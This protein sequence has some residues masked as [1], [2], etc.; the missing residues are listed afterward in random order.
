MLAINDLRRFLSLSTRKASLFTPLYRCFLML[1]LLTLGQQCLNLWI[2]Q[3]TRQ[4]ADLIT[5]TLLVEKEAERL[6]N[7]AGNEKRA[8]LEDYTQER[9]AFGNSFDHLYNLVKGNHTQLNQL[10]QIK[11]L[12]NPSASQLGRIKLFDANRSTRVLAQSKNDRCRLTQRQKDKQIQTS[13]IPQSCFDEPLAQKAVLN[14]LRTQIQ[15]LLEQQEILLGERK[16]RLEQLYRIKTAMNILSTVAILLGVGL[17]IRHLHRKVQAPLHKL[18]EVGKVWQTGQMEVRLGYSSPN[19]IGQLAGVLDAM[20]DQAYQRQQHIE[21][22]NQNL[23]DL[24]SGLSHDMRTPLLATRTTL[25]CMLMGT[26]RCGDSIDSPRWSLSRSSN[27]AKGFP[28]AQ[29]HRCLP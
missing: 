18:T 21:V 9:N 23:K 10:E 13:Y 12:H 24:I 17:N 11:Y 1:I 26:T 6:L 2:E 16:H 4:T 22:C 3:K 28:D 5:R 25:D 14:S 20:A 7:T 19:E 8:T 27:S 29:A 15:S